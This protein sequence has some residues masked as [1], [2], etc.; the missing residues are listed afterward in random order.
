VKVDLDSQVGFERDSPPFHFAKHS[1][2]PAAASPG[3]CKEEA[4]SLWAFVSRN[5][6]RTRARLG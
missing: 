1:S 4:N 6:S 5:G 3:I 2:L